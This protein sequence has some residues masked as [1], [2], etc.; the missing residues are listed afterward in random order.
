MSDNKDY[1]KDFFAWDVA[2]VKGYL[3][4]RVEEKF[5]VVPNISLERRAEITGKVFDGIANLFKDCSPKSLAEE[6]L[7]F[8]T[9][10]VRIDDRWHDKY[11]ESDTGVKELQESSEELR[12]AW[13]LLNEWIKVPNMSRIKP[14]E[15]VDDDLDNCPTDELVKLWRSV[16]DREKELSK[17]VGERLDRTDADIKSQISGGRIA[18]WGFLHDGENV[19][20]NTIYPDR[21]NYTGPAVD[22]TSE[23]ETESEE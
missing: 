15:R 11:W 16:A 6:I 21:P 5:G 3:G 18:N 1:A 17:K 19:L 8:V 4:L 12:S 10:A 7:T 22:T 13:R 23:E 14:D 2:R 20:L 9:I